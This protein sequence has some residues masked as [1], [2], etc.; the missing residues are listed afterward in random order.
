[1]VLVRP[2]GTSAAAGLLGIGW[3]I[4]LRPRV[5]AAWADLEGVCGK[6]RAGLSLLDE[7]LAR[8]VCWESTGG[9]WERRQP[10]RC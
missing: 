1:M 3:S 7:A 4:W 8:V 2:W 6:F 5:A 10:A 9:L